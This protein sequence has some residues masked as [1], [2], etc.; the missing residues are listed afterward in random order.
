MTFSHSLTERP[1]GKAH[2]RGAVER[3]TPRDA[4]MKAHGSC[5]DAILVDLESSAPEFLTSAFTLE[6]LVGWDG[7]KKQRMLL[8]PGFR[9]D[10]TLWLLLNTAFSA[11][12][13]HTKDGE[14]NVHE[15]ERSGCLGLGGERCS[16]VG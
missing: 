1:I 15:A 5:G 9:S 3:F 12:G 4:Y 7:Q 2:R 10:G 6:S 14:S 16:G 8:P 13:C 11:D